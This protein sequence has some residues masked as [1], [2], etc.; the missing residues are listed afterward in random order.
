[1]TI[2]CNA[3]NFAELLLG[4]NHIWTASICGKLAQ[5]YERAG[6]EEHATKQWKKC[7]D[8][9][10]N[11]KRI[12]CAKK[13][14]SCFGNNSKINKIEN[15]SLMKLNLDEL[16]NLPNPSGEKSIKNRRIK[17]ENLTPRT[18]EAL[19]NADIKN[20]NLLVSKTL[21]HFFQHGM[22]AKAQKILHHQHETRRQQLYTKAKEEWGIVQL[23]VESKARTE[24]YEKKVEA[25]NRKKFHRGKVNRKIRFPKQ[26][27]SAI[28]NLDKQKQNQENHEQNNKNGTSLQEAKLGAYAVA[29]EIARKREIACPNCDTLYDFHSVYCTTCWKKNNWKKI[30]QESDKYQDIPLAETVSVDSHPVLDTFPSIQWSAQLYSDVDGFK[31]SSQ[32]EGHKAALS[33]QLHQSKLAS[34]NNKKL[35]K[36][37]RRNNMNGKLE[38]I[39]IPWFQ[40]IHNN[41]LQKYVVTFFSFILN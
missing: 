41:K 11:C 14:S 3:L 22:S 25:E 28:I 19:V 9:Y 34:I 32:I 8:I 39:S 37:K 17:L 27:R 40:Q 15:N 2:Y 5:A 18:R 29:I 38:P 33:F 36:Q 1:M 7:L 10:R 30:I 35:Y 13:K 12:Y 23:E 21:H 4:D 31:N 24:V 6:S 16:Y 26:V 20:P